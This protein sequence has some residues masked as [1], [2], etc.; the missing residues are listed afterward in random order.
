MAGS[1]GV[2]LGRVCDQQATNSSL[3]TAPNGE[4]DKDEDEKD[5]DNDYDE[6]EDSN[7]DDSE[8]KLPE[9]I[10]DD[11]HDHNGDEGDG[12]TWLALSLL[13]LPTTENFPCFSG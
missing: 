9:N 8:A 5:G 3:W 13:A 11:V 2:T 12:Q 6:W 7:N 1:I 4:E 10:A